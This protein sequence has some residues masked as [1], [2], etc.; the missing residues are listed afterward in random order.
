MFQNNP[1]LAQLKQQIEANKEYVEGKVKASDK[2][3]GFLE[4]DKKS[5]FIPP[6]EMKKVMHGDNV[7][8]VIKREGD[9]ESVEIDSLID[10]ML[11]RFIARVRFNKDGKLQLA[12]DHPQIRL[13]IPATTHKKVTEQL[14]NDDWVVAQ[15]KSH[16][17]RDDRFFF[18]QVTEFICKADDHFA[19]WWVTLARHQQPRESVKTEQ[20]YTLQDQSPREDLSHL[21]FTTIDSPSTQDMDDALFIEPITE[22]AIQQGWRLVVA[23]ADPTAYIAEDSNIEHAARQRCFTNYLPGFNIPMLPRELS[24]DLCS[25]VPNKKRPAL[26]VYIETDLNGN[27]I[28]DASF[29][30]AWVESKAK[31]AYDNVS[32]YLEG[33]EQAWQPDCAELKQQIYWLHQ[34]TQAR[35]Q[36]RS[37][38][39]LLFKEQM[40]YN[41]ELN[42][43]GSVKSIQIQYHRIANQIIEEAMIIANIC[44][45]QFLAKHAKT[46]IFNSHAGFDPKNYEA[47][48]T[49]L[50]NT[51]ATDE[52]RSELT[53][54][55][56]PTQL[57]TL[58]G[59]CAMRRYIE[60]FPEKFLELRLRR[61]L[62]FA[63]FK[64]EVAPHFGLGI[65]HYATWT[66]PIR[67]YGDIVNHRL[68]KQVLLNQPIKHIESTIL[69]RLQ[70][71]RRQ[72]RL[73]ER[74]I[75]DWLYARYLLPIA[76][77]GVEFDCEITDISRGG[78]RAKVLENGAQIFIP[79]STLH[80]NKDEIDFIPE[81]IALYTKGEKIYQIGQATR[82]K[83]TDVRLET[84]SVLGNIIK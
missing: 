48:Q 80:E 52:N 69:A 56:S 10:P 17:L 3:F 57:A 30:T 26:V 36:W 66:S 46:G 78:I 83:L 7:K 39:A 33:V 25:L 70:E 55:F 73:V 44:C 68:I 31:L 8:A 43:D 13:N 79:C 9:K 34:F 35:I 61:Y 65:S 5:Y 29:H 77:Q 49:F 21:Y 16:P 11:D 81:E 60:D 72:N 2:N 64:A 53:D 47:V 82:V 41:F 20:S 37:K 23:I 18:A 51:L 6:L 50:L 40:D 63:E 58:D 45:A 22:N 54:L 15:L 27:L 84:R 74:D 76:T 19:P 32:D 42:A 38:N 1:L 71:A 62:T 12:V 28:K 59:Y 4:A 24:D 67:K 75:A 14:A